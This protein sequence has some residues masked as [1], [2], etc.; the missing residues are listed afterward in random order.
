MS[1]RNP[2]GRGRLRRHLG[3]AVAA[4][5]A[6]VGLLA[7]G[8]A[9]TISTTVPSVQAEGEGDPAGRVGANHNQVLV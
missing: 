5:A 2:A 3:R 8:V 4:A 9:T 6:A 1:H 7:A